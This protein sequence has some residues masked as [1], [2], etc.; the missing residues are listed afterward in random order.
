MGKS[1]RRLACAA[2]LAI[3]VTSMAGLTASSVAKKKK[4]RSIPTNFSAKLVIVPPTDP[5]SVL[6]QYTA[7]GTVTSPKASC[8]ERTI[9]ITDPSSG[10]T[11]ATGGSDASGA[12]N[13]GPLEVQGTASLVVPAKKVGKKTCRRTGG[14]F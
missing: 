9:I 11:I 3:A 6:P 12:F 10:E 2:V 13:I 1:T 14:E 8:R 4:S 7:V 5:P